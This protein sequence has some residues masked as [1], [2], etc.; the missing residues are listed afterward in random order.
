M[1]Q[2]YHIFGIKPFR[3]YERH[4][5]SFVHVVLPS[6]IIL[7]LHP[8]TA[9]SSLTAA[10]DANISFEW[11]EFSKSPTAASLEARDFGNG[12]VSTI[13][14]SG[15]SHER[16]NLSG[17]QKHSNKLSNQKSNMTRRHINKMK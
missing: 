10:Y 13:I 12:S 3:R 2:I 6:K 9:S 16:R 15:L 1:G 7:A 5:Q 4:M 17:D 11:S 8:I 14:L